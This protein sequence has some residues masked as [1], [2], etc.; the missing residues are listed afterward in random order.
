MDVTQCLSCWS[1]ESLSTFSAWSPHHTPTAMGEPWFWKAANTLAD[2]FHLWESDHQNVDCFNLDFGHSKFVTLVFLLT[3]TDSCFFFFPV[4]VLSCTETMVSWFYMKIAS[5]CS[6]HVFEIFSSNLFFNFF[7]VF[8]FPA[9]E[10]AS[11]P[12]IPP[13]VFAESLLSPRPFAYTCDRAQQPCTWKA[14]PDAPLL[15]LRSS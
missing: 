12:E 14:C 13:L 3:F 10:F 5:F 8:K 1:L 2:L 9:L 6:S 4:C 11:V 15:C 7:I